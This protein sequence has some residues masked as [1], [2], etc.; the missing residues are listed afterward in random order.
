MCR[1]TSTRQKGM[2]VTLS[3]VHLDQTAAFRAALNQAAA[4]RTLSKPGATGPFHKIHFLC[5]GAARVAAVTPDADA[6]TFKRCEVT[7]VRDE[8][9]NAVTFAS[10]NT[11]VLGGGVIHTINAVSTLACQLCYMLPNAR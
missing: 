5:S 2:N 4:A 3:T 7:S 6:Q 9:N 1:A 11:A 8:Q 10:K